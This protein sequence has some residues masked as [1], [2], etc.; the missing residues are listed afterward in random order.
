MKY[1]VFAV[2][3]FLGVA[4][5]GRIYSLYVLPTD[6]SAAATVLESSASIPIAEAAG[7]GVNNST[8]QGGDGG[9][10]ASESDIGFFPG[11]PK[12]DLTM[13]KAK[14][15]Q[16]T[17]A[18]R[19]EMQARSRALDEREERIKQLEAE[20]EKKLV[21][22]QTLSQQV[23]DDLD[24]EDKIKQKKIKRMAGVFS[25]MNAQQAANIIASMSLDEVIPVLQ[26]ID[27]M[28]VGKILGNMPVDKAVEISALMTQRMK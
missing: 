10:S 11:S 2:L 8:Q 27:E 21:T 6:G 18:Y 12:A 4:F 3:L 22:L 5:G 15:L 7:D 9:S 23:R 26:R 24:K 28:Q 1:Y 17:Q 13:E 19:D 14:L 16:E 20:L 25:S